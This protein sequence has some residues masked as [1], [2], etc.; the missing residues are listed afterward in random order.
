M[1]PKEFKLLDVPLMS[2]FEDASTHNPDG[3]NSVLKWRMGIHRRWKYSSQNLSKLGDKSL[4]S[5]LVI[6]V[7]S[8][9][10]TREWVWDKEYYKNT[11]V[12]VWVG[13]GGGSR[14]KSCTQS[15]SWPIAAYQSE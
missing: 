7:E 14:H 9:P 2:K 8:V 4:V 11:C 15:W 13:V 6:I 3:S 10:H 1:D 12:W 5:S